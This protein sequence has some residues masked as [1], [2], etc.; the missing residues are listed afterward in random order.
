M[1]LYAN[2]LMVLM[3]IIILATLIS[4]STALSEI[5]KSRRRL[6]IEIREAQ[7]SLEKTFIEIKE[8]LAEKIE[9]LDSKPGLSPEEERLREEIFYVLKKSEEIVGKEI[10]DIKKELEER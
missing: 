10:G 5:K 1:I 3:I 2:I 7:E 8:E 4:A 6:E 9:Y